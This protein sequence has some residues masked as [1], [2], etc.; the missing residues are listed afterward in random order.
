M[1]ANR[2]SVI[3]DKLTL[4]IVEIQRLGGILR[5]EHHIELAI[6]QH[7]IKLT[8]TFAEG[9]STRGIVVGNVDGG[10]LALL[11]VIV[12]TLVLIE[13]ELAIL[14]SIDVEVD[15]VAVA[16][17][18]P[19]MLKY[20]FSTSKDAVLPPLLALTTAAPTFMCLGNRVE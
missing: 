10:I 12:R 14:A 5:D 2:F 1:Y 6:L 15:D 9:N 18:I 7:T 16:I 11:V 20:L 19:E 13:L 3:V 8:I 4:R 17:G